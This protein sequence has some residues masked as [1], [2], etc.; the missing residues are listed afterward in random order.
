MRSAFAP[1]W[2]SA[3]AEQRTVRPFWLIALAV[4]SILTWQG[5]EKFVARWPNA[6]TEQLRAAALMAKAAQAEIAK[7]KEK[8]Q[9]MQ[10][11]DVDPN[12]TGLIGP[13]WSETTTTI[14]EVQAKRTAT[15][16]DL[17]AA[18]ARV[19]LG[20]KPQPGAAIGIIASGSFP[21][22]NIAAISAVETLGLKPVIVSSLGSSMFG[23]N[24]PEFGW[25]DMESVV[26]SAGV[27]RARTTA[28]V[29]GGDSATAES[30]GATG[31]DM[32]LRAARRNGYEPITAGDLAELK[33]SVLKAINDAAPEGLIAVINVGGSVLGI[34]TCLDAYGIPSGVIT[35]KLPCDRGVTGM[36]HDFAARNVSVLHLLYI[37][38]LALDWGLPYDPVP[39]PA[40]GENKRIYGRVPLSPEI[41]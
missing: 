16:P 26:R 35:K 1:I 3:S 36:V 19:L 10:P 11:T 41:Q 8:L 27:W 15:N 22:A 20:F 4:A 24:D 17:A 21:G 12:R 14:G 28:V 39:L 23:A 30:L 13:E 32:L 34:G 18:I 9:W 5:I 6:K 38:R 37:K 29:L 2:S 25:L 31:R 40:V 33:R 7:A